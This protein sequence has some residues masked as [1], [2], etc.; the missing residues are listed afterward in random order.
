MYDND[1]TVSI[2]EFQNTDNLESKY[3][4]VVFDCHGSLR[5]KGGLHSEKRDALKD[6]MCLLSNQVIGRP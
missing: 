3:Y 1:F 6:A 4:A 2:R 5:S